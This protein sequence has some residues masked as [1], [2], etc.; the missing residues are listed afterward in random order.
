MRQLSRVSTAAVFP[1]AKGG[2]SLCSS[3]SSSKAALTCRDEVGSV[4][5]VVP[6][7]CDDGVHHA[8]Q[9]KVGQEALGGAGAHEALTH[10][11]Q[12]VHNS[13]SCVLEQLRLA[14]QVVDH[15][16]ASRGARHPELQGAGQTRQYAGRW[17]GRQAGKGQAVVSWR[18]GC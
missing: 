18:S 17:V 12:H 1:S 8:V 2:H 4:H 10:T 3:S 13:S 6:V 15:H 16:A 9:D 7:V 14:Q 5:N 11:A